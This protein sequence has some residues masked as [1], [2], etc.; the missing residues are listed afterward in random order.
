MCLDSGLARAV[1]CQCFANAWSILGLLGQFLAYL[2][3]ALSMLGICLAY[4]WHGI[5]YSQSWNEFTFILVRASYGSD[6]DYKISCKKPQNTIKDCKI[7][8][9]K[10]FAK[11]RKATT[12]SEKK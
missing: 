4:N 7:Q 5:T 10:L 9:R 8:Y 3:N 2:A 6:K 1:L 11:I 12:T